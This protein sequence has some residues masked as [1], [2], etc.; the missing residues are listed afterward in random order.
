[1]SEAKHG[2]S[3]RV[4]ALQAQ[5]MTVGQNGKDRF[6]TR[7]WRRQKEIQARLSNILNQNNL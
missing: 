3:D 2:Q 5:A 7:R 4:T 1:M 6:S